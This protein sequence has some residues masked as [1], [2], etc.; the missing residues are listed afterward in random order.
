MPKAAKKTKPKAAPKTAKAEWR[1]AFVFS[2]T[3]ITEHNT[4][5]PA[6]IHRIVL[7]LEDKS[8]G[9]RADFEFYLDTATEIAA[10]RHFLGPFD[11]PL[12]DERDLD[13]A[14]ERVLNGDCSMLGI[15]TDCGDEDGFVEHV[16]R[17]RSDSQDWVPDSQDGEDIWNHNRHRELREQEAEMGNQFQWRSESR[18]EDEK[19][20]EREERGELETFE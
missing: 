7:E 14:C 10:L 15:P 9:I 5:G 8:T 6:K 1:D 3:H 4:E 17:V 16:L 20:K 18:W 11:F 13:A 2:A 12:V 19:R